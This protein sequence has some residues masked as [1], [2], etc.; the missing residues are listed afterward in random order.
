MQ[1]EKLQRRMR[2]EQVTQ[3]QHLLSSVPPQQARDMDL[4]FQNSVDSVLRGTLTEDEEM[5]TFDPV[6]GFNITVEVES[7]V[8]GIKCGFLSKQKKVKEWHLKWFV[9]RPPYLFYFNKRNDKKEKGNTILTSVHHMTYVSYIRHSGRVLVRH[10]SR[11]IHL[12]HMCV[13]CVC[14]D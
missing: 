2:R 13:V 9:L 3:H 14:V 1:L 6:S 7:R 11:T 5:T 10:I 8:N 12:T 4:D